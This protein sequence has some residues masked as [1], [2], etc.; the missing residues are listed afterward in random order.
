MDNKDFFADGLETKLYDKCGVFGIYDPTGDLD[1]ARITY[2]AEYGLQHRG[3]ESAGIAVSNSKRF[4][5]HR[6][7]GLVRDVFKSEKD[8]SLLG[9]G[10]LAVGHNRYSTTGSVH[11]K[12]AHPFLLEK[13]GRQIVI[14][15]NGNLV[16]SMQL[17]KKVKN[18]K[19]SSTTDSEIVGALLLESGKETWEERFA[20]IFPQ[21]VGAYSFVIATRDL[22]FGVRDPFGVRPLMLGKLGDGW[23][24]SSEDCIFPGIG[25]T[26]LREVKPGEAVI[27]D[28]NGPK[29]FYQQKV[30]KEAFCI[31][32][33]VYLARP[34]SVLNGTPVGKARERAGE[35]LV[36]EAPVE[37]DMVISV[38]DSGMTAAIAFARKSGIPLGEGVIKNRYIGRTFIQPDPRMR[39]LGVKIKFGPMEANLR[40]KRVIV[41]DDSIV[42]GTTMKEF[43]ALL[44]SYGAKEVHLRIACPPL[45]DPC[46]Y[47]VDMPTKEE[48]IA[49]KFSVDPYGK[50]VVE[51][52]RE[53]LGATSLAYLSLPGLIEAAGGDRKVDPQDTKF[54]TACLT[55][56]YKVPLNGAAGKF[57]LENPEYPSELIENA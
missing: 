46:F 17:R 53:F 1:V 45:T 24:L 30:G 22:L 32:E 34:D 4:T 54:C 40:G 50:E 9:K 56:K 29:S 31:F 37:A 47:G 41:V 11:I 21:I 28:K 20:E 15:H 10:L 6:G 19:L 8:L 3:Q 48:L 27:I 16:N 52:V 39:E 5:L 7:M 36:E 12:N 26:F 14:C 33:Y 42:R 43:V 49:N 13:D 51:K 44:R 57:Q 25:A 2:F 23:V 35:L 55:G 38:P 18:V